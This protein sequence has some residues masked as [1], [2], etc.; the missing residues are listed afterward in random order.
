[1]AMAGTQRAHAAAR[2]PGGVPA[3]AHAWLLAAARLPA[4]VWGAHVPRCITAITAA[5]GALQVL[6]KLAKQR[7]DSI[8]SYKAGGRDDLVGD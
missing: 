6:Q 3:C 5:V 1:M 2:P 4:G 8:D 7:K